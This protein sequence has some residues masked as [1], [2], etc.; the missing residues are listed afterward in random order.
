MGNILL[1]DNKI[2]NPQDTLKTPK[3]HN[4]D[5]NKKMSENQSTSSVFFKSVILFVQFIFAVAVLNFY[6]SHNSEVFYNFQQPN[7]NSAVS[8]SVALNNSQSE[9]IEL[10]TKLDP[11]TTNTNRV[12]SRP[13]AWQGLKPRS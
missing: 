9:K 2:E 12:V 11:A 6:Q 5:K 4:T 13:G 1:T 3:N 7:I 8:I 10:T